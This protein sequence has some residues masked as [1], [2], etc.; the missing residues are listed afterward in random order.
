VDIQRF[1]DDSWSE[2]FAVDAA[3]LRRA[4]TRVVGDP[5]GLGGYRGL[6]LLRLGHGC[7]VG[8]PNEFVDR[9]NDLVRNAPPDEIFTP[10]RARALAGPDAGLVLGPS[11]HSYLDEST[12]V[13]QGPCD[14]RRLGPHD[15]DALETLRAGVAPEEWS[16][17]GFKEEQIADHWGVFE[18]E[19][20]VAAGNMT[21]FAGWR[22]DVGL[23]THPQDRGRG[24]ATRLAGAMT[25]DALKTVP[26][27]RYRALESNLPS[28][29]VCRKLGFADHG[30]N[31]AVRLRTRPS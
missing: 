19:R 21:D 17:G 4:G 27:I 6:Y 12:F 22:A 9:V 11:I 2:I 5:P 28:R 8:V 31:I 30:A 14:A 26:V 23:V 20:L 29:A 3:D 10:D 25:A 24:L 18:D 7:T 13:A 1:V 16:E 15:A